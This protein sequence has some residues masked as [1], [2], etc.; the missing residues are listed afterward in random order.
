MSVQF[1]QNLETTNRL[2]NDPATT[3]MG[4]Y[5]LGVVSSLAEQ[6]GIV[7]PDVLLEAAAQCQTVA[8]AVELY[9]QCAELRR[10][11]ASI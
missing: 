5:S 10:G 8:A 4:G 11:K 9:K 1:H 2:L 7:A 6:E 3:A